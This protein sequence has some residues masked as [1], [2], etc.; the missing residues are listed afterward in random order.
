MPKL[1]IVD[2]EPVIRHSFQKAF[3][4]AE[5]EVLTAGTVA[6]GRERVGADGPD[7]IVVDLQLPD[8]SGLELLK[9]VAETD[10]RRPVILI[11]ARGTADAAIEAMTRGAFDYLLKPL[12]LESFTRLVGRAF[13]AARL[14]RVPAVLPGEPVADR[15]LGRA[16]AVQE[17]CKAIGRVAPQDVNVLIRGESGTGKELVAR[18]IYHHSR[19]ANKPFLAINCAALPESLVES[20]LFG[21]EQGAFTGALRQRVGKFEQCD[22]GTLLLDEIGDMPLP[23]QAKML[24]LLQEQQFERVGGSTPITTRVRVLAA[25]N[26]DLESLISEGKFRGDLFYRLNA[27]TVRVPPLRD[28]REDIPELAHHFLDRYA[29]EFGRD[30]RAFSPEVLDLWARRAWPGNVRELQGV[31]KEVLLRATGHTVLPEFL[32]TAGGE[33]GATVGMP[34]GASPPEPSVAEL[35]E[36]C[37]TDGAGNVY[38]R[39]IARVER[40]LVT[41][42]L[43]ATQGHQA[44]AS[45][46]LGINRTTL[47]NKLRELGVTLDRVVSDQGDTPGE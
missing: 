33:T 37:L 17:M 8:G 44:Q 22:G 9:W 46:R 16:P 30:V 19:R 41:Q 31:V 43:R 45:D 25:T 14:M 13:E 1:L 34:A 18:A 23:V 6:E 27:V 24:R 26:K 15:I 32:S 42:A 35:I 21:H 12:D 10:P 3:A 20:E 11:T 2:D 40:A 38:S 5:V 29:R 36:A 7:V 28:R 47:R 4:S 39:V